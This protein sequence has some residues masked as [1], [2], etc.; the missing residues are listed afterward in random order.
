MTLEHA[1]GAQGRAP[2][3]NLAPLV[4]ASELALTGAGAEAAV[5]RG[6]RHSRDTRVLHGL[7]A[8]P[9][10]S[11]RQLSNF[12]AYSVQKNRPLCGTGESEFRWPT[13]GPE[14]ET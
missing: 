1:Q 14:W 13:A 10:H 9:P 11:L 6:T 12:E 5:Q 8:P 4:A 7:R 3:D 2:S